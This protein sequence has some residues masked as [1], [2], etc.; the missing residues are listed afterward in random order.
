MYFSSFFPQQS[1]GLLEGWIQVRFFL[2]IWGKFSFLFYRC[3]C[4]LHTTFSKYRGFRVYSMK[5]QGVGISRCSAPSS[6][7]CFGVKPFITT[8]TRD[9]SVFIPYSYSQHVPQLQVP[10]LQLLG[11]FMVWL[12]C[13]ILPP[14]EKWSLNLGTLYCT[15]C[16]YVFERSIHITHR[17][18]VLLSTIQYMEW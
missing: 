15:M 5:K 14:C 11:F 12:L 9:L 1:S 2:K 4:T 13:N 7:P 6:S 17:S 18:T 16:T 3:T 8:D 10:E